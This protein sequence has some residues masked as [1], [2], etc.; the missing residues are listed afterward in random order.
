M[1]FWDRT[2]AGDGVYTG[3]W[4]P[5]AGGV[6][7]LN[8]QDGV[9][10]R[11]TVD[12]DLKPGFPVKSYH[13]AGSYMGGPS[14]HTLV[15][16]IDDKPDLE[17][18]VTGLASGPLYAWKPDGSLVPGWPLDEILG[19]GYPAAG[20]LSQSSS[21]KEIGAT[22]YGLRPAESF[23]SAYTGSGATLPGWPKKTRNASVR[24]PTLA[25]LDGDGLDEIITGQPDYRLHIYDAHGVELQGWPQPVDNYPIWGA[26][27]G[28]S[29]VIDLDGDGDLDIVTAQENFVIAYHRDGTLLK[30]FPVAVEGWLTGHTFPAIGDVDGDG[31]PEIVV[32]VVI[33][34]DGDIPFGH[35]VQIISADGKVKR[36]IRAGAS[37]FMLLHQHWQISMAMTN[38]KLSFSQTV[39]HQ[40]LLCMFGAAMAAISRV[41]LSSFLG[42]WEILHPWWAMLTE[43]VC[44]TFL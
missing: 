25:D 8:F 2:L 3:V 38:L 31:T 10:A 7:G 24:P 36:T 20:E 14:L 19:A 23:V 11:V 1:N 41:G 9:I 27:P 15:A 4:V 21:G 17:I 30:G 35:G 42:T 6:C 16:N 12:P 22:L 13:S 34:W 18:I 32:T 39:L 43:T 26:E 28:A 37:D 40:K 29:A 44:Q 33:P 5:Q